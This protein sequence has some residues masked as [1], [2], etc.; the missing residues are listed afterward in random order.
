MLLC[1]GSVVTINL[2][3]SCAVHLGGGTPHPALGRSTS[4][5]AKEILIKHNT[6]S[7]AEHKHNLL[8]VLDA[9]VA[10]SLTNVY[11]LMVSAKVLE[12]FAVSYGAAPVA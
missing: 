12:G 2:L 3:F 8:L 10:W 1:P 6:S 5:T 7:S 9:M 11:A 4:S